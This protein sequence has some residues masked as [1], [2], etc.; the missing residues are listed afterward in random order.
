MATSKP[1]NITETEGVS[2]M[3]TVKKA[4]APTKNANLATVGKNYLLYLNTGTDEET[5]AEWT[6]LG[7]QRSGDLS[8]KSDS[9][10]ASHKG[11]GGWK[12]TL[13]GLKEWSIDLE[14]LL[15]TNDEGLKALEQAFLDD[16]LVNLKF[17][18]PDKSYY[19]GWASCT[20]LSVSAPHDDVATYKGSLNGVGPLSELKKGN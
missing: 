13:P 2:D 3:A 18:Y 1:T 20:E 11:S 17:E 5:G 14:T 15:M 12:T 4:L 10:D 19:T 6:L 7:G 8:R 16:Q 9:I